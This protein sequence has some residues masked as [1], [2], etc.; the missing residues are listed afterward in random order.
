MD[1]DK[2]I[3]EYQQKIKEFKREKN[4]DKTIHEFAIG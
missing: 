2:E 4:C 1:K 3:S